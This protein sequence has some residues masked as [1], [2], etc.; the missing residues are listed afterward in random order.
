MKGRVY[1]G[2]E[3]ESFLTDQIWRVDHLLMSDNLTMN[4]QIWG[5]AETET[6]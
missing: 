2:N 3:S 5:E 1:G 4:G 6:R